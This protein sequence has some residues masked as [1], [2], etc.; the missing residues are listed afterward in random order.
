GRR[1]SSA[2]QENLVQKIHEVRYGVKV[3]TTPLAAMPAR[4]EQLPRKRKYGEKHAE[5]CRL[6]FSRFRKFMTDLAP[7]V[8]EMGAVTGDQMRAF[9]DFEERLGISNGTWNETLALLKGIYRR[10]E[11]YSD[12]WRTYLAKQPA[13]DRDVIHREPFKAEELDAVMAAAS[14]EPLM[15]AL[16][17][18]ALCTA[19]RRGDVCCLRWREVDLKQGFITVKT[20]KTGATVD[21]PIFPML[22]EEL[23]KARAGRT[24]QPNDFVFPEAAALFSTNPHGLNWRLKSVLERAGFVDPDKIEELKAEKEERAKLDRLQPDELR[25]CGMTA[26][27]AASMSKG[28]RARMQEIFTRYMRGDSVKKIAAELPVSVGT[29][30]GH[31]AELERLTGAAVVRRHELPAVIRGATL[32]ETPEGMVRKHRGALRG[33]HSFRTTW[34]T[35]ALTAGVSEMIVRRVTGHATVDVVMKFYFRPGRDQF[36]A[37]LGGALP[38]SLTGGV[39]PDKDVAALQIVRTMTP[40]T[41]VRDQARLLELLAPAKSTQLLK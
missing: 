17:V 4:W 13:K 3:E 1:R 31:L 12:A 22:G 11:P 21:I 6:I 35:L 10:F 24:P 26:I 33:W 16:I 20:S 34:I 29:V 27:A 9:M 19:M 25:R 40:E 18:T 15:K 7:E 32:A 5:K 41:C 37:T 14:T 38:K 23:E 36:R 28:R 39:L 30:S 2:D 8:R